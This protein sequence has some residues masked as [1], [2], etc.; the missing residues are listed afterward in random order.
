MSESTTTEH[1]FETHA[2]VDLYVES[3]A[4]TVSVRVVDT[5]ESRVSIT[6]RDADRVRVEQ[7]GTSLSVVAPR[8]TGFLV[9]DLALDIDVVVPL[10]SQAAVRTGSADVSVEGGVAA[11][12]VRSGSGEVA[13]ESVTGPAVLE[14]GSG[15]V[16]VGDA[17]GDLRVKSGSGVVRVGRAAGRLQVSTGSGDVELATVLGPSTVKT[18]SGTLRVGDAATDVTLTTGSG[19]LVLD[20]ASRGRVTLKGASADAVVGVP[21]GT[22]VWT[23]VFTLTGEIR[24]ALAP[25]GAPADGADHLEL[26]VKTVSGDVVLRQV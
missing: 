19:H 6:G 14:T 23:D 17:G 4:G 11:L 8:R 22:P 24:N 16:R 5:T 18:G 13:V 15:E 10:R 25:T 1:H 3:G 12:Q 9:G 20:R 26:R 2:P 21:A 7:S